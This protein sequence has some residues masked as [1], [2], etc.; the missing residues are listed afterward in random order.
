MH[1]QQQIRSSFSPIKTFFHIVA[2]KILVVKTFYIILSLFPCRYNAVNHS[3]TGIG[4]QQK[5]TNN[6]ADW[7]KK[8]TQA[9]QKTH[10]HGF[11]SD[12]PVNFSRLFRIKVVVFNI[13]ELREIVPHN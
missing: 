5:Q 1:L 2:H 8:H 11:I 6:R 12:K 9:E 13:V 4:Q 10:N 7:R 3:D